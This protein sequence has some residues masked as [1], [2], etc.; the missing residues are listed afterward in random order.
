MISRDRLEVIL[1]SIS[2][3]EKISNVRN[4]LEMI[5]SAIAE[6]I[7]EG[8]GGEPPVTNEVIDITAG[9]G[10]NSREFT[11][12]KAPKFVSIAYYN[13]N[14]KAYSTSFVPIASE[15]VTYFFAWLDKTDTGSVSTGSLICGHVLTSSDGKKITFYGG[16]ADGALNGPSASGKIYVEY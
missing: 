2:K 6:K 4:R 8:G 5:F 10:T 14:G 11:F 3:G 16:S 13:A 12:E 1:E 7:G 15:N 9:T